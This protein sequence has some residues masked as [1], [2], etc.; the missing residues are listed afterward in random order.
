MIFFD[1]DPLEIV[2]SKNRWMC[3]ARNANAA[4]VQYSNPIKMD[5]IGCNPSM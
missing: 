4:V 1:V 2:V 3:G 5:R